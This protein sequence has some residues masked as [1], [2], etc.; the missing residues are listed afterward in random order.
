MASAGKNNI[1]LQQLTSTSKKNKTKWH[2]LLTI[3]SVLV[4]L[5]AMR[6]AQPATKNGNNKVDSNE[7]ENET[8][9]AAK[10]NVKE[11][12]DKYFEIIRNKNLHVSIVPRHKPWLESRFH[13][14]FAQWHPSRQRFLKKHGFGRLHVL[15]DDIVQPS[16][17]FGTHSHQNQEIFSYILNGELSHKHADETGKSHSEALGRGAVQYM[18]LVIC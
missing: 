9:E 18:S 2:I 11:K 7:N 4:I 17:G 10:N 8:K 16:N 6:I 1:D 12:N 13:F 3:L 15:N 5:I 14:R